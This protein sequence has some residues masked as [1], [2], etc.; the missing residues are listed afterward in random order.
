MGTQTGTQTR[1][2]T[3][4]PFTNLAKIQHLKILLVLKSEN[5]KLKAIV[6]IETI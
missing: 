3:G 4:T 2:Q 6:E 5:P 1:T